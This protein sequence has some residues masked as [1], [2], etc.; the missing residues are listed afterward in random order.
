MTT[1]LERTAGA[2][3]SWGVCEVPGWGIQLPVERVL[4]EMAAVGLTATELGSVGYLPTEADALRAT[5]G[6]H[7]LVLTGGFNALALHDAARVDETLEQVRSSARLLADAGATDY[8]SCAVSDPDD[9]Q[10]IELSD[11]DW[12]HVCE[13][14]DRVDEIVEPLGLTQVLHPHVDSLVE[15]ADEVQRV[16]DNSDVDWVLDTGHLLIGGYDPVAFATRYADRVRLVH[17]KDLRSDIAVRLNADEL[18]L[19]EAVQEG[20]FVPLGEGDAAIDA[21]VRT[22]ESAGYDRWYV[23][24]QDAAITAGEPP[25]GEGPIR[26]VQA[27]VAFIRNLDAELGA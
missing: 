20:L 27:S 14:L 23:I 11:V 18:T 8:V 4:R 7:G 5:L 13:M 10:R 26:D 9:W 1:V 16:L 24:E 15:T 17:L 6:A 2:P 25:E 19:M 22:M 12:K 21:V 3:I